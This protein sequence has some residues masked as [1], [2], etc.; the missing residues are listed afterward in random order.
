MERNTPVHLKT[1]ITQ[2]R[3]KI[4]SLETISEGTHHVWWKK[5]LAP[6]FF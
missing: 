3:G 1:L 5:R 4:S 2:R 6:G